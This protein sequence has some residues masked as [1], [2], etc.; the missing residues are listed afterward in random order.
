[1]SIPKTAPNPLSS[2]KN[3]EANAH[4]HQLEG[5]EAAR[6]LSVDLTHGLASDEVKRRQAEFGMNQMTA[7]R[8][9]PA[10][11]KFLQ[12]FNQ[13]LVYQFPPRPLSNGPLVLPASSPRAESARA[14]REGNSTSAC[15][16]QKSSPKFAT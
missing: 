1:M 13:A 7:R 11:V 3:A 9:T 12:Q 14:R 2:G 10:W 16:A 15:S 4:W 5:K 8:G 6:R